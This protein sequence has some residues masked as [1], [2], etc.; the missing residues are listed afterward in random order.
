[1]KKV[2]KYFLFSMFLGLLC[3]T[4]FCFG[5]QATA[6]AK[7]KPTYTVTPN[8]DPFEGRYKSVTAYNQYTKQYFMLRTYLQELENSGGGK[9][10]LKKGT[11]SITN[12]LFVPSNVTI[13]LEDGV[14]LKKGDKTGR[15]DFPP[16]NSM[17]QLI[18]DLKKQLFILATKVKKI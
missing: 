7:T 10:V 9:L 6:F 3:S 5:F 2:L 11:Y 15:S 16:A 12:S 18:L 17:F 1:M 4:F 13:L 8:T 14:V